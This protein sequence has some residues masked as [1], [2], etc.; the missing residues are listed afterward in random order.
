MARFKAVYA[1]FKARAAAL[2]TAGGG[3]CGKSGGTPCAAARNPHSA[4]NPNSAT[5]CMWRIPLLSP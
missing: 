2:F 5:T 1:S 4:V 3:G